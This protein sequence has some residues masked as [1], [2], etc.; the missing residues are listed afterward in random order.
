MITFAGP[1]ELIDAGAAHVLLNDRCGVPVREAAAEY[2]RHKPEQSTVV[3][4]RFTTTDGATGRAYANWNAETGRADEVYRK[5][6]TL[7]PRD[8]PWGA[9]LHR[10]D[11]HTVVYMFPNDP[12]LRRMRWYVTPRKLKRTL[13]AVAGPVSGRSEV[14]ILRYKPERRVVAKVNLH[15]RTGETSPLLLRYTTDKDQGRLAGLGRYLHGQGVPTPRPVAQLENG[16][17]TIDEFVPGEQLREIVERGL[18]PDL[19]RPLLDLHRVKPPNLPRRSI[20]HEV[21]K[22]ESGLAGLAAWHPQAAGLATDVGRLLRDKAP[23]DQEPFVLVHGDLHAKNVLI[24]L[25]GDARPCFVDLERAAIGPAAIDLGCYLA[26]ARAM[27]VR[28]P[29]FAGAALAHADLTVES[30][31]RRSS[32]QGLGWHVGIGLIDQALLVARHLEP[33]W[34]QNSLALLQLAQSAVESAQ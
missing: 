21:A 25:A 8:T 23:S 6:A 10:A 26:H 16:A 4:F 29:S 34:E 14:T 15:R 19:A 24:D 27:S 33:D 3:A 32:L 11:D 12:R 31:R 28:Q 13:A 5:A 17:V 18:S 7:R 9:G 20:A 2:V 1:T 22:A 30:Y